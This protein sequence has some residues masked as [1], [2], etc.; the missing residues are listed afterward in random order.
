MPI[1]V[2]DV[3]LIARIEDLEVKVNE[4]TNRLNNIDTADSQ[5]FHDLEQQV[6][7]LTNALRKIG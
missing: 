4:L 2:N 1:K 6:Q 5:R 3:D 7:D